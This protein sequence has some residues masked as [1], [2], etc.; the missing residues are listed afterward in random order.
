MVENLD[1]TSDF[2]RKNT[3]IYCQFI[4]ASVAVSILVPVQSYNVWKR[5]VSFIKTVAVATR[6]SCTVAVRPF[7]P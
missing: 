7:V 6:N 5:M 3:N 4:N 1:S 2:A